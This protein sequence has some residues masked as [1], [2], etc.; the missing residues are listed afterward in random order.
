MPAFCAKL[1]GLRVKH[2]KCQS[3]CALNG[4]YVLTIS[5]SVFSLSFVAFV[6]IFHLR[7]VVSF[8]FVLDT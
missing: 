3:Q 7:L 8:F 1:N 2:V 5:V 4:W 6:S